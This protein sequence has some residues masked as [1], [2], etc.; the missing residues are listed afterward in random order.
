MFFLLDTQQ[1]MKEVHQSD[2]N[3]KLVNH[4]DDYAAVDMQKKHSNKMNVNDT[5]TTV[6]ASQETN[7]ANESEIVNNSQP[8]YDGGYSVITGW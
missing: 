4:D 3:A 7:K 5:Y 1:S 2:Q 8:M 6:H